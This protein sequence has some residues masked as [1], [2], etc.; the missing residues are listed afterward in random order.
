MIK[1]LQVRN[2]DMNFENAES[3][4]I[5]RTTYVCVSNKHDGKGYARIAAHTKSCQVFTG[6]MLILQ[7]A[8]KMPQRGLLVDE[9]GALDVDDLAAMTRFK[10]DVF[11]AAIDVLTSPKIRWLEWVEIPEVLVC[12]GRLKDTIPINQDTIPARP[13]PPGRTE[14]NR[15]EGNGTVTM[16]SKLD[17]AKSILEYLNKKTGKD[18]RLI[19]TH[20]DLIRARLKEPGVDAEGVKQMIDSKCAE[21]LRDAEMSKFLRPKTLFSKSNFSS[22]YDE[23]NVKPKKHSPTPDTGP[24]RPKKADLPEPEHDWNNLLPEHM[25][26]RSWSYWCT[27]YPDEAKQLANGVEPF[28]SASGEPVNFE[29]Y[30]KGAHTGNAALD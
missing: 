8:S 3:R 1:A 14:Q 10:C 2:W 20:L 11:S 26:G 18:Y 17:D 24:P 12:S 16:S 30:L 23:R 4:K 5:N 15:T 6:W 19:P 7:V 27:N 25:R 22:Y 28:E 9:D 21:W 29:A 13:D